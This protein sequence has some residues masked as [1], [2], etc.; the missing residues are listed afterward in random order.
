MSIPSYRYPRPLHVGLQKLALTFVCTGMLA[1]PCATAQEL[2]FH[3]KGEP[4]PLGGPHIHAGTARGCGPMARTS[5]H[6]TSRSAG[7][8]G[9]HCARPRP[10]MCAQL[11]L[12]TSPFPMGLGVRKG[13]GGPLPLHWLIPVRDVRAPTSACTWQR[14]PECACAN[15]P[16]AQGSSPPSL[17]AALVPFCFMALAPTHRCANKARIEGPETT[18]VPPEMR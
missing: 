15:T 1:W 7:L 14:L 10:G 8:A 16:G 17:V 2:P 3:S 18:P 5:A 4:S 9:P 12:W 11:P 6:A 13:G